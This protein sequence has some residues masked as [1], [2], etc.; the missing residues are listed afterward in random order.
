MKLI[1]QSGKKPALPMAGIARLLIL[2]FLSF[3]FFSSSPFAAPPGPS[4]YTRE[5][6][7]LAG[8]L[9]AENDMIRAV[10][11]MHR[12]TGLRTKLE[13]MD[14]QERLFQTIA[15]DVNRPPL[16][17][18]EAEWRLINL[19]LDRGKIKEAAKRMMTLGFIRDWL[20]LG[21]FDNEAKGGYDMPLPPE[22]APDFGKTFQAVVPVVKFIELC[23]AQG[24]HGAPFEY[25]D[26]Y[27]QFKHV[28]GR[29]H[30]HICLVG[31]GQ[32][33]PDC[34]GSARFHAGLI[35]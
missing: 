28:C 4:Y 8:A 23:S 30:G 14:A 3:L 25:L 18:G 11:L 10:H 19:D 1:R 31:L 13:D 24:E 29:R 20:I 15:S 35:D 32:H 6:Q 27:A 33:F 22:K 2:G 12:I 7:Q 21:P 17:R 5:F 16:L 9:E 26:F 34:F